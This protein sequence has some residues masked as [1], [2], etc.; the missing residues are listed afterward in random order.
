MPPALAR[1][2]EDAEVSLEGR[3]EEDLLEEGLH[4][5]LAGAGEGAAAAAGLGLG[6]F[7]GVDRGGRRAAEE[8]EEGG[9]R[10]GALVGE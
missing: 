6:R 2:P 5:R 10:G 4:R 1:T 3:M 7:G 8:E 9:K